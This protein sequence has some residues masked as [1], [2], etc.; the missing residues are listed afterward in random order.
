MIVALTLHSLAVCTLQT[1]FQWH[2]SCEGFAMSMP[3]QTRRKDL[4]HIQN[5]DQNYK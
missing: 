3:D 5:A 1:G 4:S 2:P